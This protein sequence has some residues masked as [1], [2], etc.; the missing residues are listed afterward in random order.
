MLNYTCHVK[1]HT[2]PLKIILDLI[3]VVNGK[4]F[5]KLYNGYGWLGDYLRTL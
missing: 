3:E 2:G 5:P 1:V 4:V